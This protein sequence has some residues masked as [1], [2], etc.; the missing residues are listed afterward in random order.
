MEEQLTSAL[1]EA[2]STQS[3]RARQ[4]LWIS[5]SVFFVALAVCLVIYHGHVAETDGISYYGVYAPTMPLLF[6]G[7]LTAAGGLWWSANLL[8][9][10][11]APL[12]IRPALRI[13]AVGLVVLL[14]TPYNKGAFLNWAHMITGVTMALVQ[15]TLSFAL[16]RRR[17]SFTSIAAALVLLTGGVMGALSLPDW[18][19]ALLL[20]GEILIELGFAWSLIEWTYALAPR[21]LVARRAVA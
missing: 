9:G 1:K 16:V 11:R 20:Q 21:E 4:A 6:A 17:P 15:I 10:A 5:Q 7:Y 14:I 8:V 12:L 13:L 2:V 18:H 19:I 3:Q